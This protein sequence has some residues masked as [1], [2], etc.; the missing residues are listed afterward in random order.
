MARTAITIEILQPNSHM[1]ELM[2]QAE[3]RVEFKIQICSFIIGSMILLTVIKS[4]GQMYVQSES[5]F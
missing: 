1:D 3:F 5:L 4:F 2:H